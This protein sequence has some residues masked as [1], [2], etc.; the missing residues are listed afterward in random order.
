MALPPRRLEFAITAR[1]ASVHVEL[2]CF[3]SRKKITALQ[4]GQASVTGCLAIVAGQRIP[5]SLINTLV[6]QNEYLGTR[7]QRMF[8]FFESSDDRFTRDGR[9]SIEKIFERF[10]AL[11]VVGERLD[12][13]SRPAKHRSADKNVG[14]FDDNSHERIVSRAIVAGASRDRISNFIWRR[15]FRL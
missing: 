14:I 13:H 10:S 11:Q 15:G 6:C 12:G 1:R 9:K 4:S 2:A 3:R 8:C 5:E 7:Q